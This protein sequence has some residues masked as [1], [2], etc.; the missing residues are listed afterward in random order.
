MCALE[1]ERGGDGG[2]SA[3][4]AVLNPPAL[5]LPF[6]LPPPAYVHSPLSPHNSSDSFKE[7]TPQ[8]F[9]NISR[10]QSGYSNTQNISERGAAKSTEVSLHAKNSEI[11]IEA[12]NG[13]RKV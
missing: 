1:E 8:L 13:I 12:D 7:Y 11:W 10:K 4:A 9:S 6:K 5:I 3:L 2:R